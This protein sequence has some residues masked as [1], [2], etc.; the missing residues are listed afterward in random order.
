MGLDMYL[1]KVKRLNR[2]M[3]ILLKGKTFDEKDFLD[4][5]EKYYVV[6]D[7]E[8]NPD[9]IPEAIK[10]VA[11][12]IKVKQLIYKVD[13]IIKNF[14]PEI[15][16]E[17]VVHIDCRKNK[18]KKEF[19][20]WLKDQSSEPTK[21]VVSDD[22]IKNMTEMVEKDAYVFDRE[23]AFYWRKANQIREW[24]VNNLKEPVD[25]CQISSVN[26]NELEKLIKDCM[27]VL[28]NKENAK[29]IIPTS[30]GFFF[31]GTE[32][33]EY[34]FQDIVDTLSNMIKLNEEIDWDNEAL[35]Y[36]EWW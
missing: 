18:D 17:D 19:L 14:I 9:S 11:T 24:F 23:D 36:T 33:D 5:T 2:G 4:I 21:L 25:N 35:Y 6:I 1:K 7:E 28:Q 13:D 31:G 30:E 20:I 3:D 10:K 15:N 29:D 26:K 8:Y 27:K 16:L 12:K 32:Y 22:E 34:Y